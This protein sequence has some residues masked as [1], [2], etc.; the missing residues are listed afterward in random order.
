MSNQ[1]IE[2][3]LTN[4][5]NQLS[6]EDKYSEGIQNNSQANKDMSNMH[7]PD[8]NLKDK[9]QEKNLLQ[10]QGSNEEIISK[11]YL[12]LQK[13]QFAELSSFLNINKNKISQSVLSSY[14]PFIL[15]NG[16]E[17]ILD[18][19]LSYGANVNTIIHSTNCQI[20]EKDQINLLMFSIITSNINL[21]KI[22][23]K[24][25]PNI[26]LEDKNKKNSLIYSILFNDD[27]N[28]IMLQEL[29]KL[30]K[31]AVDTIY[32]DQEN[33]MT[34]NLLTLAASKNKKNIVALL[35]EY[36]CDLNYQIPET[37]DTAM[38]LVVI[39]DNVEIA[40]LLEK[41][42][43][44]IKNIKNKSGE[45]PMDLCRGKKGKIF[46]QMIASQN[47]SNHGNF[48]NNIKSNNFGVPQLNNDFNNFNN[49][50]N[51]MN[52]QNLNNNNNF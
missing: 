34:H 46:Y 11:I 24:Y 12:F 35:L 7:N 45:S 2:N 8:M 1:S 48:N 52:M 18:L 38:H 17:H 29:L 44:Y 49:N 43:K 26:L 32:Y 19:F 15:D 14:I 10:S 13:K 20:E 47:Q 42:P 6:E 31:E 4:N 30:N 41:H 28:P 23:I 25:N 51:L 21:F 50:Q 36:N 39:N 22:V 16:D 9:D 33:N 27:N 5:P 37:G 40:L 3:N